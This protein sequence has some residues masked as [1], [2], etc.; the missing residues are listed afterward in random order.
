MINAINQ[1]ELQSLINDTKLESFLKCIQNTY[2]EDVQYHNDL[3]GT[4]VM[5]MGFYML[6]TG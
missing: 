6:T 4:D 3:H 1:L 5:Q 2:L